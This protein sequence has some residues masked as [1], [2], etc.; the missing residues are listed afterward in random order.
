[1]VADANVITDVSFQSTSATAQTNVP[2]TFGQVFAAGHVL[3]SQTVTGRLA[4][5]GTIPLQV[6][7]KARH[8]DGSARHA[9]ISATVP[10]LAA[11]ATLQVA[12]ATKSAPAVTAPVSPAALLDAGF[13]TVVSVDLNG[14]QYTASADALLRSGKYKAWLSGPQTNEW[15]A[16]VPL[17]SAAG[18]PHPHLTARFAVRATGAARARVD[19]T[20]ENGWAYEAGPQNFKYDAQIQVGGATVYSKAAM[21][22]YHHARWRKVFWWG[23]AP[24]IH[25]RHNIDYLIGS[26]AVANYDRSV[27]FSET[28]LAGMKAQWTG[29]NTEPMK[30]GLA[31]PYMPA[32]GGRPDIGLLPGW[33]ATYLLTMDARAKEST[34]GTADLS[35]SWSSHYRDKNTD[36]PVSLVDYPYMTVLGHSGDTYNPVTKRSEG[37]PSCA[38]GADCSTPNV[39]DA[40][41]QPN[42]VYLP[43]LVTGDYYYL[44]ELQFWGMWNSYMDNPAYRQ[45]GKALLKADQ[46]RGQAW[47][48]RSLAEAA[49][50]SPDAD[51]LKAHFTSFVD[52]NLD[53]Y[54]A[55]YTNNPAAN[56]LGVL[57]NGYAIVYYN[58]TGIAPWQDDFFT[59]AVGHAA[60]LGFEKAKPLLAWKSK[61]PI[62]RMTA[63]GT[64]WV[65]GAIYGLAVRATPTSP[66]FATMAE[67]YKS[68]HT[69]EFNDLKCNSTEMASALKLRVGEMTGYST[70]EIGYPSN[71]QPA[72]AFAATAGGAGGAAAWS[73]FNSRTVKPNYGVGPQFAIV[74][75]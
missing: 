75:R 32:T 64:C 65:D 4:D 34:L 6:D 49:Y 67:A 37:F 18:V 52:S 24:Q 66:L 47:A 13:T 33:A 22:H 62:A 17:T 14:Q 28:T 36:R 58:G 38:A 57:V 23:A 3:P 9:I 11:G 40:S 15:L 70:S 7:I 60:E 1:M 51:P 68:S 16:S 41:H 74:P 53:W 69:A 30:V 39:H 29:P 42:L 50:I 44:E 43:Y 2:V 61:F 25:V 54:N 71:M 10:S 35:G 19:V 45:Y 5:G 48:L 20:I 63:L 31:N 55:E 59:S 21:V 12:L 46:V 8:V 27:T 73:V 56:K 26:K 72:M